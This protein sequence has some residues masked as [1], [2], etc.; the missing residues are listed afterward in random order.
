LNDAGNFTATWDGCL[1]EYGA[2]K[3]TWTV[4]GSL[5]T[6]KPAAE[7]GL[8]KG[9]LRQLNI[10]RTKDAFVFVPD[11]KDD[12]YRKYGANAY[13]AFHKQTPKPKK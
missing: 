7:T 12:Y 4:A 10:V 3:G 6:L 13:S 8:M 5:I 2:A 11:L 1:G 9:H